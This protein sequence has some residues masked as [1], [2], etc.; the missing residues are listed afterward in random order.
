MA[1]VEA[2]LVVVAPAGFLTTGAM[3]PP[4][5]VAWSVPTLAP[6][7]AEDGL[8]LLGTPAPPGADR[9][10]EV[11]GTADGASDAS[12]RAPADAIG[13]AVV[14]ADGDA[15]DGA[16]SIGPATKEVGDADTA[17]AGIV[18]SAALPGSKKSPPLRRPTAAIMPTTVRAPKVTAPTSQGGVGLLDASGGGVSSSV[19]ARV[20][21]PNVGSEAEACGAARGRDTGVP[22]GMGASLR[23]LADSGWVV[24]IP[25]SRSGRVFT[26]GSFGAAREPRGRDKGAGD[27]ADEGSAA[28]GAAEKGPVDAGAAGDSPIPTNG[29]AAEVAIA[30]GDPCGSAPEA[31]MA[32]TA[33]ACGRGTV[34]VGSGGTA[35]C[36]AE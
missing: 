14:A 27:I 22:D 5:A 19:P 15:T 7:L 16:E 34:I 11:E 8:A 9:A 24:G 4:P 28:D 30:G 3:P 36:S 26:D 10:A 17:S 13:I 32:E 1:L 12:E 33:M 29:P 23:G 21:V 2:P 18:D 31:A 35:P 6:A 25:A 20:M